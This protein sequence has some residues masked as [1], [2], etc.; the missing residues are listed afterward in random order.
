MA[1]ALNL[2]QK[3]T[4]YSVAKDYVKRPEGIQKMVTRPALRALKWIEWFQGGLSK[5]GK[6]YR[7]AFK[8]MNY[9]LNWFNY[10]KQLQSFGHSVVALKTSVLSGA[11]ME[12]P[13]KTQKVFINGVFSIDLVADT[14]RI[15]HNQK[16]ISLTSSQLQVLST[17][18][19]LSSIALFM[20][21]ITGIRT[22]FSRFLSAERGS[23]E[24][25][26]ALLKLVSRVCL[27]AVSIFG[28]IAHFYGPVIMQLLSLSVSTSLLLFS[29]SA[30]F[31]EEIHVDKRKKTVAV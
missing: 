20:T 15:F 18:G 27:L 23:P 14:V 10:P 6:S 13:E 8:N 25:K 22:Q 7:K 21:A 29:L 16:W 2:K 9:T 19:F 12:L 3:P 28:I 4:V 30:H 26:V 5:T 17:I 1:V 31:Y 11:L 24:F